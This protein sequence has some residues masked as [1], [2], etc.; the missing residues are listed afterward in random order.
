MKKYELQKKTKAQLARIAKDL[1]LAILQDF[2]KKDFIELILDYYTPEFTEPSKDKAQALL[3][4]ESYDMWAHTRNYSKLELAMMDSYRCS[5][6][7][8]RNETKA[9]ILHRLWLGAGNY[10]LCLPPAK[11]TVASIDLKKSRTRDLKNQVLSILG[12]T[13]AR[14]VAKWAKS[15][16]LVID[17]CYKEHWA[18]VLEKLTSTQAA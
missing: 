13:E 4:S 16:G 6:P 7:S 1:G 18:L 12:F 11:A 17:L 2:T 3:D 10:K 14:Q 9:Q 8:T 15:Q 5:P